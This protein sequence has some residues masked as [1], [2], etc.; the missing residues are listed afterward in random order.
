[1]AIFAHLQAMQEQALKISDGDAELQRNSNEVGASL[2]QRQIQLVSLK[3]NLISLL[4]RCQSANSLLEQIAT[5]KNQRIAQD[6]SLEVVK[7][8]ESTVDDSVTIRVITVITL[9]YVSAT[10]PAVRHLR[11]GSWLSLTSF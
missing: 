9:I 10:A 6:Q 2:A 1:M 3:N 8:T 4:K 7:L 11:A 5:S